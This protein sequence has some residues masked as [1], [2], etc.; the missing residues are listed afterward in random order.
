MDDNGC[1]RARG[2]LNQPAH[3]LR[4]RQSPVDQ[5]RQQVPVC[6][7]KMAEKNETTAA[8]RDKPVTTVADKTFAKN[9]LNRQRGRGLWFRVNVE[10]MSVT[11]AWR[12]VFPESNC[13]D[14]SASDQYY[15]FMAWYKKV[16]PPVFDEV[17][18][19]LGLTAEYIIQGLKD[20][21]EAT[22]WEWDG[23][24]DC[25]VDTGRP[26]Y[27]VRVTGHRELMKIVKESERWR[28]QFLE[29][30]ANRPT[31]L[32]TPPEHATVEEWEA[33]RDKQDTIAKMERDR[34][35][36]TEARNRRLE[37]EGRQIPP[38]RV[39]GAHT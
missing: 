13:T 14:R 17:V 34:K 3:H 33:W 36:A 31:Q 1:A 32:N 21:M 5:P 35:E 28:K 12:I 23:K 27:K 37:A 25:K 7:G 6:V 15:R 29:Q 16:Y 11:T 8:P 18:D 24:A 38:P 4:G 2:Y 20:M 22:V 19:A 9:E 26:D 30:E 10:G 39:N